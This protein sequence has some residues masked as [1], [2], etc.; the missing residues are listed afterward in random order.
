[1]ADLTPFKIKWLLDDGRRD[2]AINL[3]RKTLRVRY[4][5]DPFLRLVADLLSPPAAKQRGRPKGAPRHWLEIG[6]ASAAGETIA[7]IMKRFH[8]VSKS[9]VRK[10]I[11][12][13]QDLPSEDNSEI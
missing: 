11:K 13:Y 2:D 12:F 3:A 10:A 6:H 7:A 4:G 5:D 9:H 1:M 8:P